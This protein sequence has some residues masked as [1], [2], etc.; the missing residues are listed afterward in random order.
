MH[1]RFH[2]GKGSGERSGLSHSE[3]KLGDELQDGVSSVYTSTPVIGPHSLRRLKKTL[4]LK[5]R[6]VGIYL[7]SEI[8]STKKLELDRK[9][10]MK[11]ISFAS[12]FLQGPLVVKE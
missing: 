2:Q 3:V 4:V 5:E 1:S 9:K 10:L 12:Y 6:V 7:L 8:N 11:L